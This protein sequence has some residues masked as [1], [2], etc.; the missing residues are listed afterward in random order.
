VYL[1]SPFSGRDPQQYKIA[2]V[3]LGVGAVLFVANWVVHG[4]KT[5]ELDAENL[6]KS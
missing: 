3:L 5:V 4:R 2:G 1:A 6:G